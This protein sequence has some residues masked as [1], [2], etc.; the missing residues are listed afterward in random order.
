MCHGYSSRFHGVILIVVE[1]ADLLV[2]EVGDVS[3]QH[4][5]YICYCAYWFQVIT[6]N[7]WVIYK[8]NINF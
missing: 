8:Q 3:G 7:R 1:F 5:I 2:V 6:G 4:Y